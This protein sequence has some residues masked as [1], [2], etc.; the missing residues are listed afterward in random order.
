[1]VQ[2]NAPRFLREGDKMEFST[3]IVNLTDKELTDRLNSN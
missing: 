1:M 3:K 2:P